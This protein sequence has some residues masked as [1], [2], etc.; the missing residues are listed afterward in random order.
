MD[1]PILY[2]KNKNGSFQQWKIWTV[3][4]TI[5][6]E[7]GKT[8]GK[9]QL[10]TKIAKAKSIGKK[11]ETTPAEQA[12]L[13]AQS[14]WNKKKDKGYFPS[15]QEAE[16]EIVFL[17]MLAYEMTPAKRKK[18]PWPVYVQPKMD[19]VRCLARWN[20]NKV[21][22]LSR[23][24][25]EYTVPHI[26]KALEAVLNP[27]QVLDGE[28]YIHGVLRQD[29]NALVKK[30]REEEYEDT[31]CSSKDLEFWIYD[32][33]MMDRL[34]QPF[35]QRVRY[36]LH[37]NVDR[38]VLRSVFT[39]SAVNDRDITRLHKDYVQQGFEGTIIRLPEGTYELG[40]RSNS[41][42]K[43]KDFKDAEYKIIG[44]T[45]GEGKFEG[46]AVWICVTE[47]DKKFNV[48][49]KGTLK[50]KKVLFSE[51]EKHIGREITVKYQGLSKDGIPEFPVG[52]GFRLEEDK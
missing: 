25:K 31:G 34:D 49:P 15:M 39:T 21:Q 12:P 50:Q 46:C 11:N 23:G 20:G 16:N 10:S 44:F 8:D 7:H 4:A 9:K 47:Q 45:E 27:G 24:G 2:K 22:L 19:G 18:L 43:H 48:V 52:L 37:L 33:F 35:E 13:D 51:A 28:I 32:T 36:L 42:L 30:H 1:F 26:S 5:Y 3:D 17:P 29:I 41:L 38:K 14:M 6:T 40:H